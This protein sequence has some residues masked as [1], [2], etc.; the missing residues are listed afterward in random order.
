MENLFPSSKISALS[1]STPQLQPIPRNSSLVSEKDQEDESFKI[2][3][4]EM[5]LKSGF[6]HFN[7]T[8]NVH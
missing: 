7:T 8:E 2:P 4:L 3:E 1:L 5:S 6:S